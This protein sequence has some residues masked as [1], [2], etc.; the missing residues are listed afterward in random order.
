VIRNLLRFL[1]ILDVFA[2]VREYGANLFA[3]KSLRRLHGFVESFSRHEPGNAAPHK[4]IASGMVSQPSIL[5]CRKQ[6]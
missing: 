3:A 6:Q 2:E 5:G 1:R 4:S